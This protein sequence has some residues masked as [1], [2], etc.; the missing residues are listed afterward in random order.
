MTPTSF[1]I[2]HNPSSLLKVQIQDLPLP[3]C[4]PSMM[5]RAATNTN[6]TTRKH[7][8]RNHMPH[9]KTRMRPPTHDLRA[10]PPSPCVRHID[11]TR[12][13]T[14]R[15]CDGRQARS[16]ARTV[17]ASK[18]PISRSQPTTRRTKRRG[19]RHGD[20]QGGFM[21]GRLSDSRPSM[22]RPSRWC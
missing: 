20:H 4:L 3:A 6:T 7:S 17:G 11:V 14:T 5:P 16:H 19:S 1:I 15:P 22:R 21:E 18:S 8:E 9:P 13:T 12:A 2:H 10:H